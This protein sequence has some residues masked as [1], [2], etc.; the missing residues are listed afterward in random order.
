VCKDER[1]KERRHP[2]QNQ[3]S[4]EPKERWLFREQA[5]QLDEE[6]LIEIERHQSIQDSRKL[7][8]KNQTI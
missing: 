4:Q 5:R 2:N 8:K 3:R 1:E 6:A 7:S